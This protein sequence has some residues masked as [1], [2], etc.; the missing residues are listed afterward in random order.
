M[1]RFKYFNLLSAL[2]LNTSLASANIKDNNHLLTCPIK[3]KNIKHFPA[4]GV[5]DTS[6]LCMLLSVD[7]VELGLMIND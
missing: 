6:E 5:R 7:D 1:G 3:R 4:S 2:Q